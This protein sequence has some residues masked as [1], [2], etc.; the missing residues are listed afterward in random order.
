MKT[1]LIEYNPVQPGK[2]VQQVH[3]AIRSYVASSEPVWRTK[4]AGDRFVV[5]LNGVVIAR[6]E[7]QP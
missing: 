3:D 5:K 2:T 1:K 7:I 6:L 4:R